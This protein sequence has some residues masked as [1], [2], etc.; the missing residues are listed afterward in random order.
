MIESQ[1]KPKKKKKLL[2][3]V[4]ISQVDPSEFG[5]QNWKLHLF[6]SLIKSAC[7]IMN[8]KLLWKGQ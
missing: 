3:K 8:V 7:W 1:E 4:D 2:L 5:F 6:T